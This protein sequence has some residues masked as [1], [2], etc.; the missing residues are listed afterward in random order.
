MNAG[1]VIF[2]MSHV[3][4]YSMS[5]FMFSGNTKVTVYRISQAV[6]GNTLNNLIKLRDIEPYCKF[7]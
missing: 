3:I 4:E 7:L 5:A 2:T 6:V 1:L